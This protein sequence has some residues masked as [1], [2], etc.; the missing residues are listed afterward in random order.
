MLLLLANHDYGTVYLLLLAFSIHLIGVA[1]NSHFLVLYLQSHVHD[2]FPSRPYLILCL[3]SSKTAN[4]VCI[5][6]RAR[7]LVSL[8][9]SVNYKPQSCFTFFS[10]I[11]LSLVRELLH[12]YSA[13]EKQKEGI[14]KRRRKRKKSNTK[15][16]WFISLSFSLQCFFLPLSLKLDCCVSS[17]VKQTLLSFFA[18]FYANDHWTR[19]K[20][21]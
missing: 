17:S 3:S 11:F 20:V 1:C 5:T 8:L 15:N 13:G 14:N 2:F 21:K 4:D 19:K 7:C 10:L 16:T 12:E 9:E 18:F 6:R